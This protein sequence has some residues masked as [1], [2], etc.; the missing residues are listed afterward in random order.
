[1]AHQLTEIIRQFT[2][3]KDILIKRRWEL[4]KVDK[5]TDEIRQ[6]SVKIICLRNK[7]RYHELKILSED[8]PR[9]YLAEKVLIH[10][11]SNVKYRSADKHREATLKIEQLQKELTE[12]I[13]KRKAF[14]IKARE[15][16]K[17]NSSVAEWNKRINQIK[18]QIYYLKRKLD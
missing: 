15:G 13:E 16:Y 14:K 5:T 7:I 8:D 6:L 17:T 9:Y 12:I 11:P 2:E 10:R 3:E 1:M 4:R 18:C